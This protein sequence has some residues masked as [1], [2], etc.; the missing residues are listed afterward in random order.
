MDDAL[1]GMLLGIGGA[2]CTLVR[3]YDVF[4]STVVSHLTVVLYTIGSVIASLEG[5][6]LLRRARIRNIGVS[7]F[8]GR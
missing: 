7:V 4:A 5:V 6:K 1:G 3:A 8:R 2:L